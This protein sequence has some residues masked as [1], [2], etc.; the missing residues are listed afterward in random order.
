M[1][2]IVKKMKE[3]VY[4]DPRKVENLTPCGSEQ[5]D[6]KSAVVALPFGEDQNLHQMVQ[7]MISNKL[8]NIAGEQ[9][10][11]T[12]EEADDFE[13][14]DDPAVETPWELSADQENFQHVP[15]TQR[16][17]GIQPQFASIDE[18][19]Q[20]FEI[21]KEAINKTVAAGVENIEK[22]SGEKEE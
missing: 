13:I 7:R 22:Q 21:Q 15:E 16:L 4:R 10:H 18:L 11:E 20:F 9:G 6:P 8:S 5:V 1:K 14:S 19:N 17:E 12:F 3:I 2:K